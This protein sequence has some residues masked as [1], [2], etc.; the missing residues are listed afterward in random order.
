VAGHPARERWTAKAVPQEPPP[1]TRGEGEAPIREKEWREPSA[2]GVVAAFRG[3]VIRMRIVLRIAV[4]GARVEWVVVV[5]DPRKRKSFGRKGGEGAKGRR[6]GG[7][8]ERGD[9]GDRTA[10]FARLPEGASHHADHPVKKARS[11]DPEGEPCGSLLPMES[12]DSPDAVFG[13]RGG[14]GK[15]P[16]VVGSEKELPR[17]PGPR[18][19]E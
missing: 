19:G 9:L 4:L 8:E 5:E 1:K 2:M 18:K 7:F 16:E 12:V 6:G 14:D 17:L 3:R 11:G 10:S 15:V 13:K